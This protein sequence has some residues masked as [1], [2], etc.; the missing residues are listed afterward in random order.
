[1]KHLKKKHQWTF[2]TSAETN[3]KTDNP[4]K[5]FLLMSLL[6]RDTCDSYSMGD[7]NRIVRNAYLEWLYASS[8]GHTKYKIWL[9][10]MITYVFAILSPKQSVEYKWNVTVNL[11]GGVGKTFQMITV[12]KFKFIRSKVNFK[13]KVQTSLS[14]QQRPYV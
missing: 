5:C 4:V 1:M 8:M 14:N 2:H 3:S 12:S 11:K 6:Y 7:G 9:F 10:R 13:R